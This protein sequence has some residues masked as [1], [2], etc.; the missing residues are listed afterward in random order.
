MSSAEEVDGENVVPDNTSKWVEVKQSN[1]SITEFVQIFTKAESHDVSIK[2]VSA[3]PH[4]QPQQRVKPR[5]ETASK[6]DRAARAQER[7]KRK[8]EKR[9][10]Q[11][12]VR[13]PCFQPSQL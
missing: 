13:L 4:H 7:N 3:S 8:V 10:L 5:R 6:V 9:K 2:M 11:R 12:Q 1:S